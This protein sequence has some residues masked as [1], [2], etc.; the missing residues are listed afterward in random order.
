MASIV[1]DIQVIR[2]LRKDLRDPV[3]PG[4]ILQSI[5]S[6]HNCVKSGTDL[7]GWK[8]VD[9]RGAGTSTA[10]GHTSRSSHGSGGHHESNP[11]AFGGR[12]GTHGSDGFRDFGKGGQHYSAPNA[13]F[14]HRTK[15]NFVNRPPQD[16]QVSIPLS[17]PSHHSA[18]SSTSV[19]AAA[20]TAAS[21]SP[22]AAASEKHVP[23]AMANKYVSKFK[24]NCEKVEDTIL[25]TIILGKLNKFSEQNYDEIKEF[26][27]HIIDSGETDMI[28]CF[29]KLVFEKAAS[30]E[31]FCPLYAKLL[32]Q[33]S[34][35]YP[36]LLSEMA[37]LYSQYMEIFEE[38]PEGNA[39]N[40]NEV[41]KRNVEKKYRRGYSQFLAE[42]IKHDVIDI[43]VFMKTVVKIITQVELNSRAKEAVKLNEEF[44][45][46]LMKIMKAIR[47]EKKLNDKGYI[48]Y[49]DSDEEDD[50][51][52]RQIR[53]L[54]KG[55]V[56]QRI[57]P[58]TQR[59]AERVGISNKTRF[60]ILDIYE[61][62]QKF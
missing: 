25:N 15:A 38:I 3:L 34:A 21:P 13:V 55:D 33:L 51:K 1:Q 19:A 58:L 23:Y 26:I 52:I 47:D 49:D 20:S 16:A 4:N 61:S 48:I 32:G 41:C 24:K 18:G 53:Q 9:W 2:S 44:A 62:I 59:D 35:R 36:I 39:A 50:N 46:C 31:I 14:G 7:N 17:T 56:F 8:K 60:T 29:M 12:H 43:D 37:N 42:L 6:I 28:K 11:S 5:E 30:E 57:A 45:D 40:Y 22:M 10:A 54:L 27:T